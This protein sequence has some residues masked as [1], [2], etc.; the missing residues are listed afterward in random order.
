LAVDPKTTDRPARLS[1]RK[2]HETIFIFGHKDFNWTGYAFSEDGFTGES[3]EDLEVGSDDDDDDDDDDDYEEEMPDEDLFASGRSDEVIDPNI[4][5]WD[6]RTYFLRTFAIRVSAIQK[7][8]S[9]FF[10]KLYSPANDWASTL[11][12]LCFQNL[13]PGVD[14]K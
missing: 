12:V 1:V 7:Q 10:E 2:A 11:N 14:E 13:T 8:Y 6:P 3:Q 9:Y 5:I 4:T